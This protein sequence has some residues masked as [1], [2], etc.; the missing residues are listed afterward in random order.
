MS[1]LTGLQ[2]WVIFPLSFLAVGAVAFGSRRIFRAFLRHHSSPSVKHAIPLMPTLGALFAF[3]SAFVIATEWTAQAQADSVVTRMS[4]ASARLAW[5][6]TA[7]GADTSTIQIALAEDLTVTSTKGWHDLQDGND[8]AAI[9]TES[10]RHLEQVVRASAYSPS[11]PTPAATELIAAVDDLGAARRELANA[12]TRSLPMVLFVALGLSGIMLT[13][14][15]VILTIESPGR[16]SYVVLSVVLLVAIDLALLL[17]L[18]AP[19]RGSLQTS[20][21]PIES[22]TREIDSGFFT[23]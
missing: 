18:A 2:W 19:F 17:V 4:S 23:R 12:A 22:I 7:P 21:A 3:L 10:F 16:S 15:A 9:E 11:V 14:N 20:P 5:A 13:L 6:A 1:R 8:T